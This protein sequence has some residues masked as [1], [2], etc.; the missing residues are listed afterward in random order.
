MYA[1][2]IQKTVCAMITFM[3]PRLIP[4]DAKK[5]KV[6][7]AVTISGTI[8]GNVIKPLLNSLDLNS[9]PLTIAKAENVAIIVASG[10]AENAIIKEFI[11]AD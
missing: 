6:A 5:I 4:R 8:N 7:T 3:R 2:G 1:K 9:P 11:V 10:A